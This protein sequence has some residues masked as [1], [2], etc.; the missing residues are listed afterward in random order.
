MTIE[1]LMIV[2]FYYLAYSIVGNDVPQTLGTF[3]FLE[4]SPTLVGTL[5]V[6]QQYSGYWCCCMAGLLQGREM[7]LMGV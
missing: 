2:G 7:P 6:Y 4:C 5:V 1:I 3:Y